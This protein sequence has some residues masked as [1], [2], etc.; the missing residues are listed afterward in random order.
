MM[1]E[2]VDGIGIDIARSRVDVCRGMTSSYIRQSTLKD[3]PQPYA[4]P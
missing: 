4:M 1:V 2:M 3:R